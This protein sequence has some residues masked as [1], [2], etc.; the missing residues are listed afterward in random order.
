MSERPEI[1]WL[2]DRWSLPK[3]KVGAVR[4]LLEAQQQDGSTAVEMET[5]GDWGNAAAKAEAE[6]SSPL[7]LCE[8]GKFLQSRRCFLAEQS[9]AK[10]IIRLA[11]ANAVMENVKDEDVVAFFPDALDGDLQVKAAKT[12]LKRRLTIITGGPGTGKTYTLARVLAL[13]IKSG[14]NPALI[15]LAAPTGKAADRMREAVVTALEKIQNVPPDIQQAL[16]RIAQGSSTLHALLGYN[17]VRAS[18][19]YGN[20]E[21]LP[22]EVLIV[23]E[24]SMVDVFL[25]KVFLEALPQKARLILLGDPNQLQSVGLGG[26]L[27]SLVDFAKEPNSILQDAVVRLTESRRF[28][29]RQ[30]IAKLAEYLETGNKEGA[31]TLLKNSSAASG[32]T[33]IDMKPGRLGYDQIPEEIRTVIETLA[34][35]DSPEAAMESLQKV[36]I[37]SAHRNYFVGAE[38]VGQTIAKEMLQRCIGPADRIP[39]EPII[40]AVNDPETGLRNGSVGIL[41]T[42]KEGKREA[43]FPKG[44]SLHS[45]P[46]ASLPSYSSAW[47]ISIHRSQGS[48]YDNILVLLPN[49]ESPL[50]SRELIY[51]AITRAKQHVFVA[52]TLE[53]ILAAVEKSARRVTLLEKML[54]Y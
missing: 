7:V 17:P 42:D 25:W 33:W 2:I 10:Q 5:G 30:G 16:H 18:V 48:E 47:A 4:Y 52:G 36:C 15:R 45:Y 22:F 9:V 24:C 20:M 12:A 29:D 13:L 34:R 40:I 41:H 27:G 31:K 43:W 28:K 54:K 14:E 19:R 3:D 11:K 8:N 38:A 51:T 50:T 46:L 26:V 39:N 37:L 44:N 1:Q 32:L 35:A 21:P 53:S 23:D 6:G 49:E